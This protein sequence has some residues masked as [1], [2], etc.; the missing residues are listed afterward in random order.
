[1]ILELALNL[2]FRDRNNWFLNLFIHFK[3]MIFIYPLKV[4]TKEKRSIIYTSVILFLP[5]GISGNF[6]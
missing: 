1:M 6:K 5:F 2:Y 3:N 4:A